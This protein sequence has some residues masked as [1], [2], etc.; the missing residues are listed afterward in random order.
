MDRFTQRCRA[1][2]EEEYRC[3]LDRGHDGAHEMLHGA[4]AVCWI[5]PEKSED[6]LDIEWIEE[7]GYR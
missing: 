7:Q 3:D 6:R 2:S 4:W 5:D 1:L